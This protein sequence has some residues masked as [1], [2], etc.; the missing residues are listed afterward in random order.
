MSYSFTGT[1]P[2]GWSINSSTGAVTIPSRGTTTGNALSATVRVT[3]SANGKSTY[4][5]CTVS[6]AA[7]SITNSNYNPSYSNY[8]VTAG[9]IT[10]NIIA[11]GG[12][13]S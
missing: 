8:T 7:N 11:S 3:A 9:T 6:Q 2:S 12:S 1:V 13:A 5:D 4:K 10:D